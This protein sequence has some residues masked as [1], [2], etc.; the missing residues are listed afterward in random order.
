MVT[1][2]IK[3]ITM[4]TTMKASFD[5]SLTFKV[6]YWDSKN[7]ALHDSE[8]RMYISEKYDY[9]YAVYNSFLVGIE[10]I[11]NFVW[12]HFLECWFHKGHSLLVS[13]PESQAR[14]NAVENMAMEVTRL[15][16][17][18]PCC[19]L[20]TLPFERMGVEVSM[21]WTQSGVA[22]SAKHIVPFTRI[23]KEQFDGPK[24]AE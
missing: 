12:Y 17:Y 5:P 7:I 13:D 15:V 11:R 8:G 16:D 9:S 10:P 22:K 14:V 2:T 4:E 3:P 24:K 1:K 6:T 18:L 19:S 23:S 21:L 20:H